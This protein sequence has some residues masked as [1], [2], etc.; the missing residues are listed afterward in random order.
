MTRWRDIAD[1]TFYR[2]PS[3]RFNVNIQRVD[4]FEMSMNDLWRHE[5]LA[6]MG[7]SSED[8]D[9]EQMADVI[10]DE[11][12]KHLSVHD[13]YRIKEKL[14]KYLATWEAGHQAR[15]NRLA[16][17]LAEPTNETSGQNGTS[18]SAEV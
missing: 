15:A 14:D 1:I 17:R 5:E 9:A 12:F 3:E 8:A 7:I 2:L 11:V 4:D 16:A 6:K 10:V 13:M 18:T